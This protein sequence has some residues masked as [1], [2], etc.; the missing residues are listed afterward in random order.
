MALLSSKFVVGGHSQAE[1][2]DYTYFFCA[3]MRANDLRLLLVL[4]TREK[5][6]IEHF[7]VTSAFTQCATD[8]DINVNVDRL[9]KVYEQSE[10]HGY[11]CA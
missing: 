7:H 5:F 8:S 11:I 2:V 4:A 3:P 6:K 1:G 9:P 10:E